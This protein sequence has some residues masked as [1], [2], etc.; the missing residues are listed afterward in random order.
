MV[1]LLLIYLQEVIDF[2]FMLLFN[3]THPTD[4]FLLVVLGA[5]PTILVFADEG[6]AS[7]SV[8]TIL[9]SLFVPTVFRALLSGVLVTHDPRIIY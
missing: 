1:E 2:V 3:S 7:R 5:E 4:H 9:R 8:G 6:I